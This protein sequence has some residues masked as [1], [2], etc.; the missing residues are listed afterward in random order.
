[1][2]NTVLHNNQM[3]MLLRALTENCTNFNHA[4]VESIFG[5]PLEP[6][7]LSVLARFYIEK[8]QP[9]HAAEY[10]SAMFRGDDR[11]AFAREIIPL[12]LAIGYRQDAFEAVDYLSREE[13]KHSFLGDVAAAY[14][15]TNDRLMTTSILSRVPEGATRTA[16]I[17][18]VAAAYADAGWLGEA[19]DLIEQ[20]PAGEE[21]EACLDS[22]FASA[23]S[24]GRYDM[25]KVLVELRGDE[26]T[27]DNYGQIARGVAKNDGRIWSIS[28]T[29]DLVSAAAVRD[30]YLQQSV[31]ALVEHDR[32]DYAKDLIAKYPDSAV[33]QRC[34]GMV[35]MAYFEQCHPREAKEIFGQ[36]TS[37]DLRDGLVKQ[38]VFKRFSARHFEQAF[39]FLALLECPLSPAEIEQLGGTAA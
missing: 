23:C 11:D 39:E 10:V 15:R 32:L 1:M 9:A 4:F 3:A 28:E 13:F 24:L 29:L 36:M 31:E 21:K 8:K 16:V 33:R 14:A 18:K 37:G 6:Y 35:A 20:L 34:L 38:C 7:E 12:L 27:D 30:S 25:V 22:I 26:L 19:M 2:T 5:R 17:C